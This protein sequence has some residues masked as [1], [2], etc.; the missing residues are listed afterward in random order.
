MTNTA[1]QARDRELTL[2]QKQELERYRTERI[3]TAP[4]GTLISMLLERAVIDLDGAMAKPDAAERSA[5]IRHAQDIVL[6]LRC[7]I[8][9]SQGEV[10]EN[11]DALYAYVERQCLEAFLTRSNEPLGPA[12]NVLADIHEGWAAIL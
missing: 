9:L 2:H 1:E 11:L 8:D 3:L 10:A 5:L 7:C 6:E 12:R 4:P